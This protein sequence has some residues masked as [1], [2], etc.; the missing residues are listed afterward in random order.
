MKNFALSNSYRM[1]I[2]KIEIS[3]VKDD[4]NIV[5]KYIIH[6]DRAC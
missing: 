2:I 3:I 4:K 6:R 1:G 5:I